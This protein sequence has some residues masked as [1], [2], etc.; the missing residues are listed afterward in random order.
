[1]LKTHS[2][3]RPC[4]MSST[5][6]GRGVAVAG[7][8]STMLSVYRGPLLSS[9]SVPSTPFFCCCRSQMSTSPL[10]RPGST[11]R[12]SCFSACRSWASATSAI[13]ST[14]SPGP[15]RSGAFTSRRALA[16]KCNVTPAAAPAASSPSLAPTREAMPTSVKKGE[17]AC[18]CGSTAYRSRRQPLSAGPAPKRCRSLRRMKSCPSVTTR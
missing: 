11:A 1:M 12:S 16:S 17:A 9:A 5:A 15:N 2:C 8:M 3:S 10:K 13:T 6:Q 18:C 7:T 14:W 4:G